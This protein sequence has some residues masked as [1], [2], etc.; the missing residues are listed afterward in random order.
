MTPHNGALKYRPGQFAFL[1]I[2]GSEPH[3]FTISKAPSADGTLRMTVAKLGDFTARMHRQTL[4]QA[5][6]RIEG[7]YGRFERK[8][9]S[10]PELWI[11]AG[12]GITPFMAWA[13]S[14]SPDNGPVHLLYCVKSEQHAAHLA[15]LQLLAAE[16][17][18]LNLYLHSS[19]SHT[20][21]TADSIL[22]VTGLQTRDLTVAFC[23]PKAMRKSLCEGFR[24]NGLA[25]RNFRYEEFEI[26]TG[27]GL[28]KLARLLFDRVKLPNQFKSRGDL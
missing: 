4:N 23:G 7:A 14:L 16:K 9:R 10:A 1:S 24:R 22:Q 3:P 17:D 15:E 19:A 25:Q 6:L 2:D 20:R 21:A 5:E 28:K 8:T 27:I 11:A 12:I 13:Q 18:N 26:R